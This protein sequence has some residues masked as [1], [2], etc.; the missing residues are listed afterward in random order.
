[1]SWVEILALLGPGLVTLRNSLNVS[2][3]RVPYMSDGDHYL[4][5]NRVIYRIIKGNVWKDLTVSYVVKIQ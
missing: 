4:R 1:M 2:E 3:P 5:G